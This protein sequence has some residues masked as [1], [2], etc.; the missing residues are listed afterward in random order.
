MATRT[1]APN[2]YVV[3]REAGDLPAVAV[4]VPTFADARTLCEAANAEVGAVVFD[5][6]PVYVLAPFLAETQRALFYAATT[7]P[8]IA[9]IRPHIEARRQWLAARS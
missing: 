3:M 5:I 8:T 1:R 9:D 6:M 4:E 7:E 2:W